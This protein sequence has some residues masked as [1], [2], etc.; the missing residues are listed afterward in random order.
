MSKIKFLQIGTELANDH[1]FNFVK[2]KDI[3]LG[4]LVEP[5]KE[6]EESIM[7]C[8]K[9]FKNIHLEQVA[10]RHDHIKEEKFFTSELHTGIGS[11]N[12][13]HLITHRIPSEKIKTRTVNCI[14]IND[15]FDKYK[16]YHLDHFF[17]DTEGF[18]ANILLELN[19]S[20]Y[21]IDHIVFEYVHLDGSQM[22]GGR[23]TMKLLNYL[24]SHGYTISNSES[25]F[26][27]E[28]RLNA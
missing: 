17:I 20:K 3:E 4:V 7:E 14:N 22:A 25:K 19:L 27:M 8:Y 2:D 11:F 16:L 26:N 12:R 24:K 21:Q 18:D 9:G 23:K 1:V 15:L 28:A 5:L 6:Y 13:K 10:V